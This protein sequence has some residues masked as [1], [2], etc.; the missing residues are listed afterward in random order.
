MHRSAVSLTNLSKMYRLYRRPA[1]RVLDALGVNRWL[2][3]RRNYYQQFW[4]I[5]NLDLQIRR[6]ERI[7][8]IGR[9]GAGK[10]TLLKLICGN[11]APTEGSV[12]VAG[13]IQALM[14]LGTGFHPEFTGRQNIRA[15]LAYQACRRARSAKRRLRSSISPNWRVSST[16]R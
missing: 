14:E 6:G 11:L 15:S 7:G 9:N 3:W 1:D 13:R 8:I 10:S 12:C 5:R 4:P 16:N 2:F